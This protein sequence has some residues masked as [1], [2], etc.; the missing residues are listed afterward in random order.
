[1]AAIAPEPLL[2]STPCTD[3]PPDHKPLCHRPNFIATWKTALASSLVFLPLQ[4]HFAQLLVPGLLP[5][6]LTAVAGPL[7]STRGQ[8]GPRGKELG[9][10]MPPMEPEWRGW[11]YFYCLHC[12][13]APP[14]SW[15]STSPTEPQPCSK[16]GPVCQWLNGGPA[17]S[18]ES[19]RNRGLL[20]LQ[21]ASLNSVPSGQGR[22]PVPALPPSTASTMQ[23]L[24]FLHSLI[25]QLLI[26]PLPCERRCSRSWDT[27]VHKVEKILPSWPFLLLGETDNK[28]DN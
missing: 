24:S 21:E 16:S 28:E 9:N 7:T 23:H 8:F 3:P 4:S 26:E 25:H 14:M 22:Y 20:L 6:L 1:M 18:W 10:L 11:D 5:Q 15:I 2:S 27:R 13:Q 17:S 19:C 12:S